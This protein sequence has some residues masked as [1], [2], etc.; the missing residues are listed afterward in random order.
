MA[1]YSNLVIE[2]FKSPGTKVLHRIALSSDEFDDDKMLVTALTLMSKL[3]VVE[4][5]SDPSTLPLTVCLWVRSDTEL[6]MCSF[7]FFRK[8]IGRYLKDSNKQLS[9]VHDGVMAVFCTAEEAH[10]P[11]GTDKRERHHP[12]V[13]VLLSFCVSAHVQG[14]VDLTSLEQL[15]FVQALIASHCLHAP[16]MSTFINNLVEMKMDKDV[17]ADV[18]ELADSCYDTLTTGRGGT[19][20]NA[21]GRFATPMLVQK[22]A[23]FMEVCAAPHDHCA[24]PLSPCLV[25]SP[26]DCTCV[27]PKYEHLC[28]T[29]E[30]YSHA[31]NCRHQP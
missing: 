13:E 29:C 18:L 17:S 11:K 16:L 20:A 2:L 9:T 12:D 27:T 8:R 7:S 19:L 6:E 30:T 5:P 25:F 3:A 14:V 31:G 15:T 4:M 21:K 24:S 26:A 22:F 28:I 10:K 23:A 1:T